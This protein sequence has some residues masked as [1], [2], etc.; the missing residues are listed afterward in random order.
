MTNRNI[1]N[2]A[3]KLYDQDVSELSAQFLIDLPLFTRSVDNKGE[4]LDCINCFGYYLVYN[5]YPLGCKSEQVPADLLR[6]S[7]EAC[8]NILIYPNVRAMSRHLSEHGL[9]LME[10]EA[11]FVSTLIAAYM[12]SI[13]YLNE[14]IFLIRASWALALDHTK[15]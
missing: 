4:N 2:I 9:T 14:S 8:N 10:S 13:F 1:R 6:K 5:V 15:T 3:D 11:I 7:N 12:I